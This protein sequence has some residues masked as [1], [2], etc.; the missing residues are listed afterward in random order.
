[1]T[2]ENQVHA[3]EWLVKKAYRKDD[4]ARLWF[5][6][7]V[8]NNPPSTPMGASVLH[9]PRGTQAAAEWIAYPYSRGFDYVL[10]DGRIYPGVLPI[11]DP[12]EIKPK[13]P[14]FEQKLRKALDTWPEFYAE[15]V[16]E[17]TNMLSYLRGINKRSLPLD[18]LLLILRDAIKI[19]KRS[20]ELHFIYL[21]PSIFAYTTFEGIC[22]EF[23]I[24]EKDMRIFLQGF[25][26]KMFEI[27][28]AMW[29]LAAIAQEMNLTD[30]FDQAEKVSGDLKRSIDEVERTEKSN[31]VKRLMTEF[32]LGKVWWE[33]FEHFLE[34][35]GGRTSVAIFDVYYPTWKE[36]PYPA[37]STIKTYIQKGGFDFE[38]HNAKIVAERD[39]F[40]EAAVARI[41]ENDKARFLGALKHAQYTY[42]FKED[43]HFYF[44]QWTYSE[45]RYVIQECG[46]R[47]MKFGMIDTPEDVCFLTVTELD[48]VLADIILNKFLGVQEHGLR[49]PAMVQNRK[50]VWQDLH[51]VKNPA[52]IGTIPVGRVDDPLLIKIWGLTDE[53]IRGNANTK[54]RVAGRFEGFPGATGV[55]EGIARVIMG[56]EDFSDVLQPDDV[57]VAPFTTPAWTPLFSKIKG[58]VTDS[59]GMLAHAAICAREYNIPAVVGTITRGVR[60]TEHIRTGQRIRIDGTNGVVEVIEE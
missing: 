48:D 12:E 40:I 33:Q 16:K 34:Q 29:R 37:I 6:D 23:N 59:G 35:Y 15:G 19:S 4:E 31:T 47:L 21:Y 36:D 10:Y 22:K 56:Y 3:V 57:L 24:E 27:D 7:D 26:T 41:P 1:M 44:E 25:E 9:W 11:L 17:W 13:K 55:V 28:R 14:M 52:F 60:V 58:V 45:L 46:Y 20:W 5:H 30:V 53:V 49:I 18:R 2:S 8:H 32:E 51:E 38:E 39:K 54:D 50:Q 42:P 43:H